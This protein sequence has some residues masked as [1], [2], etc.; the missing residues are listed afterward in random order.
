VTGAVTSSMRLARPLL[1]F[2]F[3]F[4]VPLTWVVAI[5]GLLLARPT[6]ASIIVGAAWA[7]IGLGWRAWAAGTIQKNAE[8]AVDGPYALSRHPLYF[9]N[10]MLASGFAAASGRL[11]VLAAIVALTLAVYVPLIQQ[12]EAALLVLFGERY[13]VYMQTVARLVPNRGRVGR[14]GARQRF[15]WRQYLANHEYNAAIG[16]CAAIVALTALR[17]LQQR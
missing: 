5:G 10:F 2:A 9:G 4:R 12:E 3:R 16:Y 6:T 17:M 14:G 7:L 8:M 1:D 13:N 15:S 11:V